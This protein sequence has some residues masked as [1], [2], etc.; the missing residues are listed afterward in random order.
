MREIA[1][2]ACAI[3]LAVSAPAT[4]AAQAHFLRGDAN[5]DREVD[6]SDAVTTL[7]YLFVESSTPPCL[8]SLDFDDDG[9]KPHL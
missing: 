2:R 7:L 6:V 4:I 5:H 8:D 3:V 1:I 9:A